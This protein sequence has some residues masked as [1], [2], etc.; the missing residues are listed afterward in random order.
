M[1]KNVMMVK[2]TTSCTI[3]ICH[4][5]QGSTMIVHQRSKVN[6][7][8][9]KIGGSRTTTVIKNCW[10]HPS[11]Q[12]TNQLIL[13]DEANDLNKLKCWFYVVFKKKNLNITSKMMMMM[14]MVM[15]AMK[16]MLANTKKART[17]RTMFTEH[18][19]QD[20]LLPYFQRNL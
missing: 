7:A 19:Y 15:K 8:K 12:P 20:R 5:G 6:A 17:M 14:I 16:I 18:K 10:D 2:N 1:G 4:V 13:R 9:R 11:K 3:L